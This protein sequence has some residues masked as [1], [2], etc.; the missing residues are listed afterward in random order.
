MEQQDQEFA[1]RLRSKMGILV[2]F[3]LIGTPMLYTA[4]M[5]FQVQELLMGSLMIGLFIAW[6]LVMMKAFTFRVRMTNTFLEKQGMFSARAVSFA[7]VDT[8]RFGSKLSDFSVHAGD[9]KVYI[10]KDFVGYEDIIRQ[11]VDKVLSVHDPAEIE[12]EGK[13]ED[14][15]RFVGR[16]AAS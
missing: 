9:E 12:F 15:E 4:F 3:A 6:A 14:I 8:I 2:M 7:E 1:L 11:I 5:N 16:A 13:S 10:T